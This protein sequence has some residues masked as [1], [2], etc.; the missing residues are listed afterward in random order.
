MQRTRREEGAAP[1]QQLLVMQEF[2]GERFH[3]SGSL[4]S[5]VQLVHEAAMTSP[6]ARSLALPFRG[7]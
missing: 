3:P 7:G 6:V 1:G 2:S 5:S 4:V